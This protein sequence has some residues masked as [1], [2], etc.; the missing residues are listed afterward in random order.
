[1][2]ICDHCLC[3]QIFLK[4]IFTFLFIQYKK[5]PSTKEKKAKFN[6]DNLIFFKKFS[7][8]S[9]TLLSISSYVD[10]ERSSAECNSAASLTNKYKFFGTK[11]KQTVFQIYQKKPFS[12]TPSKKYIMIEKFKKGLKNVLNEIKKTR[13]S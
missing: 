13:I 8:P 12:L 1:M 5:S 7:L 9:E 4:L 3:T 11:S 2:K 6:T 10:I